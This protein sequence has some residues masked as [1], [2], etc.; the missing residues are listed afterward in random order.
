[1]ATGITTVGSTAALDASVAT[2]I[3]EF[4]LLDDEAPIM[5]SRATQMTLKPGEGPTKYI[6]NYGR[7]VAV[8]VS[9]GADIANAQQ[10]SDTQSSYSPSE[11]AV[12]VVV[13][14]RSLTRS[15][16]RSLQANTG[17]MIRRAM[18]LRVD[19]DGCAQL[20]SWVPIVGAA[21]T[22]ASPGLLSAAVA[23]TQIGNDRT[24]PE[25]YDDICGVFH[26]FQMHVI[27]GRLVPYTDVPVGTSVYGANTGAHGGVTVT[28]SPGSGSIGDEVIRRGPRAIAQLSGVP[29][30]LDANIA[31]DAS[32]DASGAVFARI[33]L[34]Y[35]QEEPAHLDADTT[36]ASMRGAVELN[37]WESYVF[38]LY[39]SSNSGCEFLAD[40]ST[41]S[42]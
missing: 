25:P 22:V 41:P 15:A 17:R 36:D 3:S 18:M 42:S 13:S 40:A 24:N 27:G 34:N 8:G 20:A 12:Q 32:D 14:G 28:S 37:G 6:D 33:G 39:R 23:K 26:P 5:V 16:D 9:D 35:V 11:I 19:Q 10:L 4:R 21:G 7:V 30:F 38:G 2:M 1:M 29:I 31:V